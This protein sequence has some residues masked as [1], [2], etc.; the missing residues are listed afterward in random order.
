MIALLVLVAACCVQASQAQCAA[1]EKVPSMSVPPLVPVSAASH[2]LCA[3]ISR[4]TTL[5]LQIGTRPS[6]PLHGAICQFGHNM[7][8]LE[9]WQPL[10]L[11][12]MQTITTSPLVD[13]RWLDKNDQVISR[14]WS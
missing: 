12:C 2:A 4:A 8:S 5:D 9:L 11:P 6:A 7:G 13:L 1:G 10:L 3:V 14:A